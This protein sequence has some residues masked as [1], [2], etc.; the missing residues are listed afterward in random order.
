MTYPRGHGR[1]IP[2]P[3]QVALAKEVRGETERGA[4]GVMGDC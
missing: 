4:Q 1:V 3:G 2:R